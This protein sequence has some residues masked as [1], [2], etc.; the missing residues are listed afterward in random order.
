MVQ[1][2][3]HNLGLLFAI[4]SPFLSSIGTVFG[5]QAVKL[6]NPFITTSIG[7]ILGALALF[8]LMGARREKLNTQKIRTNLK[9]LILLI[10]SR[11]ILGQILF[12]TGLSLT[13]SIKAIFFT[14]TEPYFV[15]FWYWL[16]G[17]E[18]IEPKHLILLAFHI[19][20]AILLSTSGNLSG[21]GKAQIGDLFIISAMMLFALS[22]FPASKLTH[23]LGATQTNSL[24]LLTGGLV[25]L[26]FAI[27]FSKIS[28]WQ[29][30]LG[31]IYLILATILFFIF[32]LTLW[33]ASLKT[34]KGWVVSALRSLG[35]LVGAPFAYF[36][37]G[38]SLNT[39]Q[40]AGGAIVLITSFLIAREHIKS[41]N[42]HE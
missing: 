29:Q 13:T 27:I 3:A 14:K 7:P 4:V 32:S 9:D 1:Y 11:Q 10:L 40:I 35:P 12:A 16:L 18:K 39:R 2:N 6:L 31:W 20:G 21:F 30:T 33:F 15:L 28:V 17:K 37:F 42:T 38:E 22:Y 36:L 8:I 26:P 19:F 5:G 41:K 24:M 23:N 34:V 25:I